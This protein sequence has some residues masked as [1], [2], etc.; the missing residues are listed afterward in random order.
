MKEKEEKDKTKNVKDKKQIC[1][2]M[3]MTPIN[4]LPNAVFF[5]QPPMN[6]NCYNK[7]QGKKPKFFVER[8]GDWICNSCK[9][10]NFAF[11]V[12]CNRCKLPKPIAPEKKE[13]DTNEEK[14]NNF[15]ANNR[16]KY[17]NK[18]KNKYK[19][20]YQHYNDSKT[21]SNKIEDEK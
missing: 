3:Y 20:N 16:Y 6:K 10:L 8:S 1:T 13:K 19:K 7:F 14:K 11:R 21:N 2:P 15:D 18:N 5:S 12:E 4:T 17:Y 9:N